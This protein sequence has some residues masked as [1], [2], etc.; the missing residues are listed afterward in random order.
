MVCDRSKMKRSGWS[1]AQ[2]TATSWVWRPDEEITR[3]WRD[4]MGNTSS[5]RSI[6][7]PSPEKN[8]YYNYS[9]IDQL[10]YSRK[11]KEYMQN[12]ELDTAS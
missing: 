10:T 1:T 4:R 12:E 8:D 11:M 6:T 2:T 5:S 7:T 3:E 9:T